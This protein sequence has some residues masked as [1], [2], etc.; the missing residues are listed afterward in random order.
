MSE[1]EM[2]E[3]L[4][5][6][7][8]EC[9]QIIYSTQI[10]SREEK[11]KLILR[12]LVND[13]GKNVWAIIL[14]YEVSEDVP[15]EVIIGTLDNTSERKEK[16][17]DIIGFIRGQ[18]E[19][20]TNSEVG[21]RN[22]ETLADYVQNGRV[23]FTLTMEGKDILATK[24]K[25]NIAIARTYFENR[26]G[27]MECLFA[28]EDLE[29]MKKTKVSELSK[30]MQQQKIIGRWNE[31]REK[32]LAKFKTEEE[33]QKFL[34]GEEIAKIMQG[35]EITDEDTQKDREEKMN[36]KKEMVVDYLLDSYEEK[37]DDIQDK[38]SQDEIKRSAKN[39]LLV[40][41]L[42]L[43]EKGFAIDANIALEGLE[44][45]VY[46]K[47]EQQKGEVVLEDFKKI[48]L[49]Q[50][51]QKF[52]NLVKSGRDWNARIFA[53]K[54]VKLDFNILR[55]IFEK[56]SDQDKE[57]QEYITLK[58]KMLEETQANNIE[59]SGEQY[60]SVRELNKFLL[61]SSIR[62]KTKED[63][64]YII[65]GI[66][67]QAKE[68]MLQANADAIDSYNY[69]AEKFGIYACPIPKV[70]KENKNNEVEDKQKEKKDL[71]LEKLYKFADKIIEE[72]N[73][74]NSYPTSPEDPS[75]GS[76]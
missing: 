62:E 24:S 60:P 19:E 14:K 13:E 48:E 64:E 18:L 58:Q 49:F 29:K 74:I 10:F 3:K 53:T 61:D 70:R 76:R 68:E 46:Q 31:S 4:K 54:L 45:N 73:K 32:I 47:I 39:T 42:R 56:F 27:K 30:Y 44:G 8:K 11:P 17:I 20:N 63:E 51:Y 40:G 22:Y 67:E 6:Y 28:K 15:Q 75:D 35:A 2:D 43:K 41:Y 16:A 21:Y 25:E 69:Y 36:N 34:K 12:D 33:R 57:L 50:N 65:S 23:P 26:Q 1:K 71:E 72:S 66:F 59:N 5:R 55:Q 52:F 38:S 37:E 7:A 9:K